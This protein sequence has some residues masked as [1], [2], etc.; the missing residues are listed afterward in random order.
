[1]P[2]RTVRRARRKRLARI[3]AAPL[4]RKAREAAQTLIRWRIEARQ[5]AR[6][7]GAPAVWA[8]AGDPEIQA[9][10]QRLDPEGG[11]QSD[12]NRVCAEAV[13]EIAGRHLVR[14]SRPL[15]DRRRHEPVG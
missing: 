1:M 6:S 5:R 4:N 13:A 15:A 10:A 9:V 14:A 2:S 8:L 12:L 11:L 3:D 7:L